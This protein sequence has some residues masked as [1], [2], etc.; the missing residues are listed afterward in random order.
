MTQGVGSRTQGSVSAIQPRPRNHRA[1]G[2]LVTFPR[3]VTLLARFYGR[4]GNRDF[5]KTTRSAAHRQRHPR[6]CSDA[7]PP[8][9]RY[10]CV[11]GRERGADTT[12]CCSAT[13]LQGARQVMTEGWACARCRFWDRQEPQPADDLSYGLCRRS[14]PISVDWPATSESDW[15]GEFGAGE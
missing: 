8:A 6:R 13:R 15:C 7:A 5:T 4:S 10:R 1:G 9:R 2:R 11:G 12:G 14:S 3:L